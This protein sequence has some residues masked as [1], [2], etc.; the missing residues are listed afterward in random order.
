[1]FTLGEEI[2]E[3]KCRKL[4]HIEI[5]FTGIQDKPVPDYVQPMQDPYKKAT[6]YF[7]KNAILDL[8]GVCLRPSNIFSLSPLIHVFTGWLISLL[9]SFINLWLF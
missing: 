4:R 6:E 5:D 9:F 1:M 3:I 8:F 7:A 2:D